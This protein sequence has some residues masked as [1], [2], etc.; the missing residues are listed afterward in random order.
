[1]SSIAKQA[2]GRWRAR[3]RDLNGR[4]RSQTFDRKVDAQDFLDDSSS[5][6]RRGEWID[7]KARRQLF[8]AWAD[9]WWATT[10]RL[11][12]TTRRGYHGVLERHVRPH[13]SGRKVTDIDYLDVEE[14]V[15]DR[16]Q[17]GLSAKYVREC[18]SVLS[19]IMKT[20][21]RANVRRDNPA[22][23][24]SL[25]VRRRKVRQGDVLDMSQALR[26]VEHIPGP[27]KSA[28]WLLLLAGLRPA[29]LCGLRVG[30]VD[31]GRR[32]VAITETLLPVHRFDSEQFGLVGGPPKTD[33][34]NRTI[35]SLNGSAATWRHS[36][37]TGPSGGAPPSPRPSTC[38]RPATAIRSIETSFGRRSSARRWRPPV[39]R[40]PYGPTTSGTRTRPS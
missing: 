25:P 8:D 33:A 31:F 19:L 7:P 4:S 2:N 14:F 28:V 20:A 38:S 39:Y 26:L 17:A 16:I 11:R 23:G 3:Y 18:L 6:M 30:S 34:G 5:D 13:F 1:M 9:R 29:E 27:Y 35:P 22:A 12:P 24:H 37:P 10:V 40:T 15:A 36:W 32:T 21:V